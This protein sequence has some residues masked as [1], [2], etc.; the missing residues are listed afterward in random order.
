[1]KHPDRTFSIRKLESED[2]L[3]EA[4]TKHTWPLCYSFHYGDL[5][6][7]SD[8]DSEA[9]PE[10]AI[11]T[12]DKTEGHHGVHGREVGRIKPREMDESQVRKIVQ[13]AKAGRW[14]SED[15]VYV[16]AEPSWHHHCRFCDLEEE[17][18]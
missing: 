4:M 16:T 17:E 12:I 13:D 5:I 1:M 15:P 2:E 3:V 8:G 10:Y 14:S 18:A 7:L 6:Y 11:V 9:V